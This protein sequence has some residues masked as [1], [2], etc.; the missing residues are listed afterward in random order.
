MNDGMTVNV[1]VSLA[2]LREFALELIEESRRMGEA[3]AQ[4]A[5]EEMS[6]ADV[7]KRL[8]VSK[9]TLWRWEKGGYLV[10]AGRVGRK[11]IYR[12]SQIESLKN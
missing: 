5:D 7:R 12:R 3:T 2:D 9:G 11:V 1:T 8:G 6:A 10:P 4:D